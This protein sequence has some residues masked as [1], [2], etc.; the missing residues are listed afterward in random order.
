MIWF[1]RLLVCALLTTTVVSTADRVIPV[2]EFGSRGLT[3]WQSKSFVGETRYWLV[4]LDDRS[5]VAARSEDSAS[6]L[7][8]EVKVDLTKTPYLNWSWQAHEPLRGLAEKTRAGDDHVA[9][10]YAIKSGGLFF[11]R[12]LSI[13]YVWSGS[14]QTGD[15]WEN[16]YTA[17][18]MVLAV[19]DERSALAQ[20]HHQKRNVREDFK[21]LF[22][23]EVTE[24]D[25]IAIMTD[26]DNSDG[27]ALAYY[28][29]IYFSAE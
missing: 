8:R 3:A 19:D 14:E 21:R 1:T 5:V 22:N 4:T 17:R 12:S 18:V 16:A 26:T 10:V 20:W 15:A 2:S 13:C 28:G 6:G 9:R 11:W 25:A 7:W 24:L 27:R 29:D 23:V